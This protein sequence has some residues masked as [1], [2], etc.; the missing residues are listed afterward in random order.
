MEESKQARQRLGQRTGASELGREGIEEA[1]YGG[2]GA[3]GGWRAVLGLFASA[4]LVACGSALGRAAS[5]GGA[6]AHY[7]DF[8]K[9][10]NARNNAQG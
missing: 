4:S 8:D 10:R 6:S 9:S 2:D 7:G 5:E 3:R 1:L